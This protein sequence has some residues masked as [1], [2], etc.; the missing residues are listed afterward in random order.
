MELG[1]V[2]SRA[3]AWWNLREMLDPNS[4]HKVAIPPDEFLPAT[5]D[6]RHRS[7]TGELT[8]PM[9]KISSNGNIQVEGKED[10][11]KRLEGQS[12]DHADAIV[13]AFW[14]EGGVNMQH[15]ATNQD[16]S[17]FAGTPGR[18]RWDYGC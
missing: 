8:T 2:N 9:W 6:D 10:I 17:F 16:A 1:F 5:S 18:S 11:K 14:P 15:F 7:L 12:T 4:D 13:M 3:A